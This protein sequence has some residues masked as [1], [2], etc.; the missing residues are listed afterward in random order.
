MNARDRYGNS[1]GR[2]TLMSEAPA[3]GQ[4]FDFSLETSI[5]WAHAIGQ[6][7]GKT[8]RWVEAEAIGKRPVTTLVTA[9]GLGVLTGWLV[10]RR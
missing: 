10:K 4:G 3:T 9:F 8:H 7:L 1:A 5:R 2:Q 6:R